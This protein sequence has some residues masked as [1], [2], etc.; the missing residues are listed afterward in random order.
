MESLHKQAG[1]ALV[2]IHREAPTSGF[3]PACVRELGGSNGPGEPERGGC[4]RG[5]F[6]S[7]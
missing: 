7:G 2:L 1:F 5:P 3:A 6:C 4:I